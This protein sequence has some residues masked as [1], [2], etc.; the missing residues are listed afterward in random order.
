MMLTYHVPSYWF[1]CALASLGLE[2]HHGG[3]CVMEG[4]GHILIPQCH[5]VIGQMQGNIS[6]GLI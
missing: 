1:L 5:A 3:V 6:H 2:L 4:N